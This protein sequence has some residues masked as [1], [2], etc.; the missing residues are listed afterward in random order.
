[1]LIIGCSNSRA[2]AKKVAEQLGASFSSLE[3]KHFPDGELYLRFLADVRGKDVVLVQSMQP[4]PTEALIEAIF[5]A[6]TARE[7]GAKRV[8]L[9]AP[10][11]CYMRQDTRFKPGECVS[12]RIVAKLLRC[13][14]FLIT[15][16][17]HLH[18]YRSLG[19]VFSVNT[20]KITANGLLA[21]YIKEKIK[22]PVIVGPDWESYQWAEEIAKQCGAPVTVMEKK[23]YSSRHVEVKLKNDVSIAGKSVVLVDDIIST[24][25]TLIEAMKALKGHKPRAF[26]CLGVH[27]LFAEGALGKLK[28]A[29]VRTIVSTDT[30]QNPTARISVAKL[31]AEALESHT[32]VFK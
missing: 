1:M 18:R 26:Y 8:G 6:E 30:I 20:M 9:V 4:N 15:V 22:N 3:A 29:G 28:R 25:H 23:R 11:L 12:S 21:A 7:L 19:V 31:L 27:G 17:P 24:G 5:A 14:D 13:V 2:L 16:D 10:Y 32:K